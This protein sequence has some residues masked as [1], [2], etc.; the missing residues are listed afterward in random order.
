MRD[1]IG[2][3]DDEGGGMR[4]EDGKKW[5]RLQAALETM[6]L[7][8]ILLLSLAYSASSLSM[9]TSTATTQSVQ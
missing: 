7:P 2:W 9:A 4:E 6:R 8:S 1:V 3:L 5:R